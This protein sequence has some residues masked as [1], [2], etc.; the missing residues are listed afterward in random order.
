M[1]HA[2]GG[3]QKAWENFTGTKPLCGSPLYN[4]MR[5][6]TGSAGDSPL[7]SHSRVPGFR[8]DVQSS[9]EIHIIRFD[10]KGRENAKNLPL[11]I[12]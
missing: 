3:Y 10:G 4:N 8:M 1:K 12:L 7:K 2:V 11:R 9:R 6:L 5:K